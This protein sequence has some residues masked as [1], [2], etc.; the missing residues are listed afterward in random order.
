MYNILLTDDEQIVIDSLSYII[1]KN[2]EGQV[3]LFTALSGSRA[4]EI[5]T[6]E[7]IDIIF[8]DINMPGL[9]GLETVS[10]ILKLKPETVIIILSAF[11]RFQYAQDAINLGAYKYITKPV[12]RN[13][14]IQTIRSA[15]DF[16]DTK[17]GNQSVEKEIQKKLDFV[18]PM[19]ENDFIFSCIYSNDKGI[20]SKAYLEYFNINCK[21]WCSL[22]L[23]FQN[24]TSQNQHDIY[25][26]VRDL[27]NENQ[28]CLV[29]TFI[30]N[31]IV[32]YVPLDEEYSETAMLE[33]MIKSL[34]SKMSYNI[35]HG[36][37]M[38]VSQVREDLDSFSELYREANTALNCTDAAGG[39]YFY[40]QLES[41]NLEQPVTNKDELKKLL[42][43]KLRQGE[44]DSVESLSL[45]YADKLIAEE[46]D[47][48]KIKNLFF[49]MIV[50]A[51]NITEEV[52]EKYS[53]EV[54][55]QVFSILNSE[56]D[57][58]LLTE[59]LQKM[60][61]EY[62]SVING[63]KSRMENPLITKVCSYVNEHLS[64]ELSLDQMAEYAGVSSFYLS[65]I[66]KEEKGVNYIGFVTDRR[67][68]M[69]QKL[70][71]ETDISIKE[72]TATIGYNDQNYF[73]RLFKN[74]FG[75]SPT[76]Y[77]K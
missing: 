64:E 30:M 73:S 54:F 65:K 75:L 28:R 42:L 18:S 2:F 31:Q 4:L 26:K 48:N 33:G 41:E 19:I 22:A 20:D 77:R 17:R 10:C 44:V 70:L 53:S 25:V 40:H 13:V 55:S 69:A 21:Y 14:V 27:L 3:K 72:I 57:V 36:I 62:A 23:E 1:N 59:Y 67:L 56:N 61:L 66:F 71:K 11:D 51:K 45:M 52:D 63:V 37:R 35:V 8:M 29:S 74:K 24:I 6:K 76:E 49:E 32:C 47:L 39:I 16:V 68:E 15:M 50:T 7:D 9:T 60:L 34:H 58:K 43:I 38:G 12:N 46:S 5:A